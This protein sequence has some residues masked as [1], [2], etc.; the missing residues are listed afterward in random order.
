MRGV[1]LVQCEGD[2]LEWVANAQ[3]WDYT[4][5]YDKVVWVEPDGAWAAYQ[6]NI[7]NKWKI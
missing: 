3:V 6:G 5:Y 4:Y 1:R 7:S 2:L